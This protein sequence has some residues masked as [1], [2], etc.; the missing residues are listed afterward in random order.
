[1]SLYRKKRRRAEVNIIPLVDVLII[2]IFFF[3]IAMQFRQLTVLNINPPKIET[4]GAKQNTKELVLGVDK[5]GDFF[6]KSGA[7]T[8]EQLQELLRKTASDDPDIPVLVVADEDVALK[9]MTELMD[10]CRAVGLT[11]IR[12]QSR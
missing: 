10:I 12:L 8:R 1:M 6:Y 11:K 3:M 4:A 7:I 5:E 2:L 9:Y